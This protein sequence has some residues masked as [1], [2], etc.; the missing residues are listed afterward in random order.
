MFDLNEVSQ[1]YITVTQI[2]VLQCWDALE[3]HF[4]DQRNSTHLSMFPEVKT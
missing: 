4:V 1:L 3:N 2:Q